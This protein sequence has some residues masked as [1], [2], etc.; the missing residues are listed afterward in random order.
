MRESTYVCTYIL[1]LFVNFKS[2]SGVCLFFEKLKK[3]A[4]KESVMKINPV[5][6]KKFCKSESE[7]N[8]AE[9]CV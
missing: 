7:K 1:D 2:A 9:F 8:H 6:K 5:K 4:S 3:K